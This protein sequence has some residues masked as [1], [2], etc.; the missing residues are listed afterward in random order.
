MGDQLV[1]IDRIF[2]IP[3]DLENKITIRNGCECEELICARSDPFE[4]FFSLVLKG[5][6]DFSS[7]KDNLLSNSRGISALTEQM[8]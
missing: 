7:M 6:L 4:N 2:T 5:D 3:G 1:D 8:K